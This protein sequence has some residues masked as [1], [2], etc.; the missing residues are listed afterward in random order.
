MEVEMLN[1]SESSTE[2]EV[3]NLAKDVKLAVSQLGGAFAVNPT[4]TEAIESL[5]RLLVLLEEAD[6]QS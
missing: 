4:H 1:S 3:I 2:T 5:N 6:L